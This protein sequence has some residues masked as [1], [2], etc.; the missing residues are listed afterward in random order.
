MTS[1]GDRAEVTGN[2]GDHTTTT[3]EGGQKSKERAGDKWPPNVILAFDKFRGTATSTELGEAAAEV[4]RSLGWHPI[5]VP[6]ADGGEGTLDALGGAN[7]TTTVSG[8]LGEPVEAGWRLE[9]KVAYIE[10]AQA[11][12]LQIVGGAAGNDP[13]EA[14]TAGTGQLIATAVELGAKTVYVFLGGSATTDG[15]LGAVRALENIARLKEIELIVGCDVETRFVDAAAVFGP[16]KGASRA[17]VAFLTRRLERLVQVYQEEFDVDVGEVPG[18][19]A[20]GGLAGG[21]LAIGGR[22]QSGF[23]ILADRGELDL[24]LDDAHLL[25]TGEGKLDL[26]SFEGKAVGHLFDWCTDIGVPVEAIVGTTD[27]DLVVPPSYRIHALD[28]AYGTERAMN[29]T[30]HLV[31]D[32]VRQILTRRRRRP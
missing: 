2:K 17:Q 18:A 24:H 14:S 28:E 29:E 21:L 13:L 4:A 22:L 16:Q 20:A 15:G 26:P 3:D 25:I 11:S 23:D 31:A 19:G 27:D 10:M 30:V 12:G 9:G 1:G 5:V 8:P 32:Q 6:M 7:K